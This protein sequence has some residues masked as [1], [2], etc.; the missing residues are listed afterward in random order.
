MGDLTN[1]TEQEILEVQA[2]NL[3]DRCFAK[4]EASGVS[5]YPATIVEVITNK[6]SYAYSLIYHDGDTKRGVSETWI[7][8]VSKHPNEQ[9][10]DRFENHGRYKE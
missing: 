6:K 4:F 3:W 1:T 8:K 9:M 2:F 10:V 5:V 7:D